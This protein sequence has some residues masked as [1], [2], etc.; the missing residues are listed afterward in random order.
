MAATKGKTDSADGAAGFS[1]SADFLFNR[2]LAGVSA[3]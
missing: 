3:R 2:S 1:C